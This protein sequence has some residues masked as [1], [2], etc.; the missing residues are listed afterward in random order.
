MRFTATRPRIVGG[1]IAAAA[2]LAGGYLLAAPDGPATAAPAKAAKCTSSVPFVAG[3]EGYSSFRIPAVVA[4]KKG[5]LVAFAEGRVGSSADSGNIDVVEKRSSDGGCTWGPLSVAAEA[6]D[7]TADNPAPVVD[8]ATGNIVLLTCYNA[9]S[10]TEAQIL[11]GQVTADQTRRVFVQTSKDDGVTWSAR[12]EI[13]SEVKL[14]NW[15]WYATG[16]GHATVLTQGPHKGRLVVPANNSVAPAAGSTDTGAESQYYGGNDFYSDDHGATWH[17]GYTDDT[18]EGF[19]NPNESTLTQLT[20]GRVYINSRDQNGTGA[21]NRVDGYSTDG[22]ATL[23][24]PLHPQDTITT[25]VVEGS[26]LQVTGP[27]SV[28]LYSGPADP[29]FRAVMGIRSSTNAGVT[30][31]APYDLTGLP[32]AYSDLVQLDNNTVG[33][34]YETGETNANA[35]ITFTR[36]PVKAIVG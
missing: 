31:S 5:T 3:T 32:A 18:T 14:P 35:N 20:D 11:A 33:D 24:S 7:D 27:N 30:W 34:L 28:L 25:P 36:V 17:I 9:A 10:V 21:G 1:A 19:S 23:V 6:G 13:T 26:V 12:R 22:G 8:P 4:T 29:T 2:V 16:P 15:R